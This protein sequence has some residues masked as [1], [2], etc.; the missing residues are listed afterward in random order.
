MRRIV[1]L[2]L[3][4][5]MIMPP[6]MLSSGC[7]D[8]AY[9][10]NMKMREN[11]ALFRSKGN[12]QAL[13]A[14]TRAIESIIQTVEG[15]YKADQAEKVKKSTFTST[16]QG[17]SKIDGH[18]NFAV[19]VLGDIVVHMTDKHAEAEMMRARAQAIEYLQ[20][21]VEAIYQQKY[22][23]I[24][25]PP[26]SMDVAKDFVGNLPFLATVYGMYKLGTAG[27]ENAGNRI[28][29]NLSGDNSAISQSDIQIGK[30]NLGDGANS[31]TQQTDL[32]NDKSDNSVSNPATTTTE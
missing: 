2:L 11:R 21:I 32:Y 26:T 24:G 9:I 4:T 15:D 20:P 17:D 28:V 6:L 5:V 12:A 14:I 10:A 19:A 27:I 23:E 18:N 29:N 1:A 30:G 25:V 13:D 3:M 16:L 31:G 22:E 7:S 8:S